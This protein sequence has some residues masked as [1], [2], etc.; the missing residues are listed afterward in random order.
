MTAAIILITAAFLML[1]F[2]AAKSDRPRHDDNFE[3]PCPRQKKPRDNQYFTDS[4]LHRNDEKHNRHKR[5][6]TPW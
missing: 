3:P 6:Q 2:I 4:Y 5:N 1:I